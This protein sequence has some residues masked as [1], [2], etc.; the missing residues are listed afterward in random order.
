MSP[1]QLQSYIHYIINV[2][3]CNYRIDMTQFSVIRKRGIRWDGE[4]HSP[5]WKAGWRN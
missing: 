3:S 2:A 1:D 5:L 4:D